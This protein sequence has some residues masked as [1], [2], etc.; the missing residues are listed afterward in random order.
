MRKS[1]LPCAH[2]SEGSVTHYDTLQV[3]SWAEDVVIRS[4]YRSLMRR[5]HPDTNRHPE[6]EM[7][8]RDITAAFAVVG[9]PVSRA[10]YDAQQRLN[11]QTSESGSFFADEASRPPMRT[12][13]MASVALAIAMSLAATVWIR[14]DAK[15]SREAPDAAD[16]SVSTQIASAAGLIAMLKNGD[17]PH[18]NRNVGSP[19]ARPTAPLPS[20]PL[21]DAASGQAN[22]RQSTFRQDRMQVIVA[23][24]LASE[25]MQSR[26]VARATIAETL[27]SAQRRNERPISRVAPS[28]AA[29]C[30]ASSLNAE[31]GGCANDREAQIQHMAVNFLNQSLANADWHK[32][33]LLLSARNRA[34]FSRAACRSDQCVIEAY[35]HQMQE[36]T[37]IMQGQVPTP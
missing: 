5:Y 30:G 21:P 18:V 20:K 26:E 11:I 4:A 17:L 27:P 23:K 8:V 22:E 33:Q 28:E 7:R 1:P 2:D 9:D 25:P 16:R 6:A 35:M 19:L 12:I 34:T 15:T 37:E 14:S 29:N 36:T 24:A 13:G 32:Q 31:N 3:V 10:A